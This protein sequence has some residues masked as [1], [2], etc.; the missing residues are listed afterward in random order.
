MKNITDQEVI[1][2]VG[3]RWFE[4]CLCST[5]ADGDMRQTEF[6]LVDLDRLGTKDEDYLCTSRGGQIIVCDKL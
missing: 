1:L 3:E 5:I 2:E 6:I 4:G